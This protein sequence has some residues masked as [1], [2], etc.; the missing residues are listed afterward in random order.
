MSTIDFIKSV[1]EAF[2]PPSVALE[3]EPTSDREEPDPKPISVRASAKVLADAQELVDPCEFERAAALDVVF[4]IEAKIGE[5]DAQ[6]NTSA[7][8][9][10]ASAIEEI[11]IALSVQRRLLAVARKALDAATARVAEVRAHFGRA[12]AVVDG[13]ALEARRA[14][15]AV[16]ITPDAFEFATGPVRDRIIRLRGE[17]E[18][19]CDEYDGIREEHAAKAAELESIGGEGVPVDP[20]LALVLIA[21]DIA[22]KDASKLL[23]VID[24]GSVAAL[25]RTSTCGLALHAVRPP[26]A[27]V[28]RELGTQWL[29]PRARGPRVPSKQEAEALFAVKAHAGRVSTVRE[30]SAFAIEALAAA[31]RASESEFRSSDELTDL[32]LASLAAQA[33]GIAAEAARNEADAERATAAHHQVQGAG[34]AQNEI[35]EREQAD[36]ENNAYFRAKAE[37]EKED[38][39]RDEPRYLDQTHKMPSNMSVGLPTPYNEV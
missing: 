38:A 17:L 4:R 28:V 9:G 29:E 37:R 13:L 3:P 32:A 33:R 11:E 18:A 15:L 12:R 10:D 14:E 1:A 34:R 16:Q 5:L 30:L 19:A 31:F 23:N 36:A 20:D 24:D 22:G 7:E 6:A 26:L 25:R 35:R 8:E 21:L 27:R 39:S 2:F